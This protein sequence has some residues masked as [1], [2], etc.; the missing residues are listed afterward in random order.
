M[1]ENSRKN[2]FF[3]RES[4]AIIAIL[5]AMLL[6]ALGSVKGKGMEATCTG[7]LKQYGMYLNFYIDSWDQSLPPLIDV[8]VGIASSTYWFHKEVVNI[9]ENLYFS[10][11]A[12]LVKSK[13][14]LVT[15]DHEVISYGMFRYHYTNKYHTPI[16]ISRFKKCKPSEKVII[17]D[18]SNEYDYNN[19]AG[20]GML[21]TSSQMGYALS[22]NGTYPRYRHGKGNEFVAYQS[23]HIGLQGKQSRAGFTF[24]D[25][26][27]AM[28]NV[29]ESYK[30]AVPGGWGTNYWFYFAPGKIHCNFVVLRNLCF[31][32]QKV[33]TYCCCRH[34]LLCCPWGGIDPC[35]SHQSGGSGICAVLGLQFGGNQ[36]M[37]CT[38]RKNQTGLA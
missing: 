11:P 9:P 4:I 15:Q 31:Y 10:C 36:T 33:I 25:G 18:A 24:F 5:A 26:H 12:A 20:S 16:K 6:P 23:G 17:A 37:G 38:F 30:K 35:G 22:G 8:E 34:I 1:A 19:W 29:T 21:A 28:M 3:E 7:N 2:E 14:G 27:V 32:V 13:K